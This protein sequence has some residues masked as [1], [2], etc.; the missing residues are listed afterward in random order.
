MKTY[1]DVYLNGKLY[2]THSTQ[3]YL[4]QSAHLHGVI[5]IITEN[6][7]Q[8]P[9][10][11]QRRRRREGPRIL[12]RFLDPERERPFLKRLMELA[13][14]LLLAF[15]TKQLPIWLSGFDPDDETEPKE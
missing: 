10:N 4:N 1:I 11:Q 6:N 8:E 9:N 12:E 2:Q 13:A 5:G 15:L 7:M 14:P 3:L